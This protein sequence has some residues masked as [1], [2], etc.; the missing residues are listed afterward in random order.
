MGGELGVKESAMGNDMGLVER[1]ASV[2]PFSSMSNEHPAAMTLALVRA[3]VY[4]ILCA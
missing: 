1:T 4:M 3:V 2:D